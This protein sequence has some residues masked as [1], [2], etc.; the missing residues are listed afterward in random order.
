MS[1]KQRA[2]SWQE[3]GAWPGVSQ[4]G[5][6][7][8]TPPVL[9][10]AQQWIGTVCGVPS[11]AVDLV[12]VFA[13]KGWS[14]TALFRVGDQS[15]AVFKANRLAMFSNNEVIYEL[16]QRC[17]PRAVPEMIGHRIGADGAWTLYRTVEGK[18]AKALGRA[19]LLPKMAETLAEVQVAFAR[20]S[21]REVSA[22]PRW[23]T[24]DIPDMLTMLIGRVGDYYLPRWEAAGGALLKR[25][26][27]ERVIDI[28]SDLSPG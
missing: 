4:G 21:A 18:S 7:D 5:H 16:L 22:V 25:G 20:L 12:E 10:E 27:Q 26:G 19:E 14:I 17:C 1:R 13:L 8:T 3:P 9:S 15:T 28:P 2:L 24:A 11:S 6:I 23:P